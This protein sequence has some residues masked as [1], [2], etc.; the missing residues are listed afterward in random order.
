MP[1]PSATARNNLGPQRNRSQRP[2]R[3]PLRRRRRPRLQAVS[4]PVERVITIET[5][6]SDREAN[7]WVFAARA[8]ALLEECLNEAQAIA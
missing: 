1:P 5:A 6:N 3:Q 2:H 7:M 8:L 4:G